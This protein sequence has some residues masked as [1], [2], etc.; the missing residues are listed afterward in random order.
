MHILA[1]LPCAIV[2]APYR[3]AGEFWYHIEFSKYRCPDGKMFPNGNFPYVYSNCT[4]KKVWDP[5][6]IDSCIGMLW[7]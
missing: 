5:P 6:L 3:T 1:V 2:P 4:V 7:L